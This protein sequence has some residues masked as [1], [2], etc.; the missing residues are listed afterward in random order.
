MGA[1]GHAYNEYVLCVVKKE[2]QIHIIKTHFN[3]KPKSKTKKQ[4]NNNAC[5]RGPTFSMRG[6]VDAF[7][8]NSMAWLAWR[9]RFDG[10]KKQIIILIIFYSAYMFTNSAYV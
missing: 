1:K 5:L 10:A 9:G 6:V 2:Q 7:F 8:K 4:N 3:F